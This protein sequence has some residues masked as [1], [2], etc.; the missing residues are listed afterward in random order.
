MVRNAKIIIMDEPTA[1]ITVAEQKK[2]YQVVKDL[3]QSGVTVIYISH[4]LEEL[5]EICDRVSVLR[6]GQYIETIDIKDTDRQGLT[7]G[8]WRRKRWTP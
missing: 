8:P 3:K 2:L 7:S 4:R 1:A 6:D 5:F